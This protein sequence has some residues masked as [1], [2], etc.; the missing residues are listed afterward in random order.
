MLCAFGVIFV[1]DKLAAFREARR[2]LKA[3]GTFLFN[4][5][6]RI[7]ENPHAA[8]NARVFSAL[9][10]G[11]KEMSSTSPYEMYDRASLE[12][13]LVAAG[14]REM[15]LDKKRVQVDGMSARTIATGHIH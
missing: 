11:D 15:R 5:W 8:A 9:F 3:G 13:L 1:P 2:V 12:L 10:P 7:E 14:F 4:V 6:D